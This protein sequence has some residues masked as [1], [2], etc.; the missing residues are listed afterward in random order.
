MIMKTEKIAIAGMT[1]ESCEKLV[2]KSVEKAGGHVKEIS[3]AKGFAIVEYPEGER[4][5]IEEAIDV[6]GYTLDEFVS[7]GDDFDRELKAFISDFM[8]GKPNVALIRQCFAYSV[9]SFIALL[10]LIFIFPG[11]GS[12]NFIWVFYAMIT[13]VSVAGAF[14]LS[15][16]Y[17]RHFNCMEGMMVGMTIGMMAGFLLGAVAGATNGMFVGSAFGM[18]VGMVLGGAA[19]KVC[20]IMGIME[21]LM[22]GIMGGTMG[23]M[24][25]VM[26]RFDNLDIFM[27]LFVA[28]CLLVLAGL[29]YMI[30][31]YAHRRG[32]GK[33][34][35][36]HYFVALSAA[37]TVLTVLV[38]TFA[39]KV[40]V[41]L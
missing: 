28:S 39:P 2:S 34:M 19:G 11:M 26:M 1:C 35:P 36:M 10:A 6:A 8:S 41:A 33:L 22:A 37:L 23:A 38:I 14:A 17:S 7:P 4:K 9:V 16:A 12:K 25:T 21:G 27:P 30:H 15:Q 3:A 29:K 18:L 32:E 24:I 40:G 13:S 5:K 31:K 20:G